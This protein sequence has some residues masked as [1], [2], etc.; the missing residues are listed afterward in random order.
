MI[1]LTQTLSKCVC[2]CLLKSQHWNSLFATKA[3]LAAR[4]LPLQVGKERAELKDTD[5]THQKYEL[6]QKRTSTDR[7]GGSYTSGDND[8]GGGRVSGFQ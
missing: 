7:Q 8:G 3:G 6:Q 2:V 1:V 5:K 4:P